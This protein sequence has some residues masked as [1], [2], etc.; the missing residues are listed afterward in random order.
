M[1]VV[2]SNIA[3]SA[4]LAETH[5]KIKTETGGV[6]LGTYQDGVWYIVETLDPGPKSIF[7]QDY[8]EYDQPY[9]SHLINK[10]ARLYKYPLTLIGLWH[11]HPGSFDIF[12][13]TDDGTNANYA[14]LRPEGALSI[15]VNLDP[16]FR[17]SVFHVG[18]NSAG[19]ARYTQLSYSVGDDKIPDEICEYKKSC[20]LQRNINVLSIRK[21][22]MRQYITSISPYF[23]EYVEPSETTDSNVIYLFPP[24]GTS[25]SPS[26][27]PTTES[28][29]SDNVRDK[30]INTIIEDLSY[31]SDT[32]GFKTSAVWN[33]DCLMIYENLTSGK[34]DHIFTFVYL[35]KLDRCGVEFNGRTYLFEKNMFY[36]SNYQ[37]EPLSSARYGTYSYESPSVVTENTPQE[38]DLSQAYTT[39][40]DGVY[41]VLQTLFNN[42]EKG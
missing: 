24:H 31:L 25:D 40:R 9:T 16:V 35:N 11:R 39:I 7:R 42:D 10:R 34:R 22:G 18:L 19:K 21:Y 13:S 41:R 26:N 14:K 5:E 1:K 37:I 20:D 2:F 8:F 4:M 32:L 30:I 28:E 6:F 38:I 29:Q 36:E 23:R 17:L 12:S 3:Y 27:Q 33:G 15:L